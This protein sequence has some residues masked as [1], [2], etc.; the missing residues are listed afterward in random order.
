[1]SD[2]YWFWTNKCTLKTAVSKWQ[3]RML[4]LFRAAGIVGGH[5]HRFRHTFAVLSWNKA[6][7]CRR[8]RMRSATRLKSRRSITTDGARRDRI[9]WTKRSARR[10]ATI[11]CSRRERNAGARNAD[12][13]EGVMICTAAE[14]SLRVYQ[15]CIKLQRD[16]RFLRNRRFEE[17]ITYVSSISGGGSIPTAPTKPS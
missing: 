9:G 4:K 1:M 12:Q 15:V 2:H 7:R 13:A 16:Q 11:R 6:R 10:G 5:P 8:S 17:S 3:F 14:A